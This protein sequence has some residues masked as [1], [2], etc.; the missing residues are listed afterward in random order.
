MSSRVK[1]RQPFGLLLR[2]LVVYGTICIYVMNGGKGGK[3][4]KHEDS[5]KADEYISLNAFFRLCKDPFAKFLSECEDISVENQERPD[6]VLISGDCI[7]GI[8]VISIPL[9]TE[10]DGDA[11]RIQ[12]ARVQRAYNTYGI[13]VARGI[14]RL[15]GHE[16]EAL[17]SVENVINKKL[18]SIFTFS[19]QGYI[20][21]CRRLL[22]EKHDPSAYQRNL[23]KDYPNQENRICLLLDIARPELPRELKYWRINRAKSEVSVR[24]DYPFTY[25]FVNLLNKLPNTYRVLMI[26]HPEYEYDGK[27]T[28]CYVLNPSS[29]VAD[30]S[31]PIIWASFD[32]PEKYKHSCHAKLELKRSDGTSDRRIE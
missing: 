6:I 32:F 7:Y 3:M 28:R 24:S 2:L 27:Q 26:W 29:C 4:S 25:A 9:V 13:D 10:N 16:D 12:K 15:S 20:N 5:Q 11:S 30:K 21:R 31:I 23:Q 18:D 14:N 19:Y 1:F 17:Q 8:E 22:L